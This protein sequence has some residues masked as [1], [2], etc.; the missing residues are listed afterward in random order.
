MQRGAIRAPTLIPPRTEKTAIDHPA[1]GKR[2]AMRP[3]LPLLHADAFLLEAALLLVGVALV[4][5]LR[6]RQPAKRSNWLVE[7]T[8]VIG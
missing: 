3:Y 7:T 6:K 4:L 5:L 1:W 2:A 8:R